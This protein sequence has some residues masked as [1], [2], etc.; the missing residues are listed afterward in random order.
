MTISVN[1]HLITRATVIEHDAGEF[2]RPFSAV[3]IAD[4]D[5]N[6]VTLFMPAGTGASIAEAI[7][8]AIGEK[9]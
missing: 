6:M 2:R 5:G 8:A 7:N 1:L 3:K 4:R 9:K